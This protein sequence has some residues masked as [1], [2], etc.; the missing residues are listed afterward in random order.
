MIWN[1]AVDVSTDKGLR[2]VTAKTGLFWPDVKQALDNED[3]REA[4]AENR[5]LMLSLG[6]W[7]VPTLCIGDYMVWGQDRIWL[8]VRRIEELCDSGE[9]ILV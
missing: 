5:Q 6:G 4:E 3:W 7:G 1:R 9:G 8:L 2:K